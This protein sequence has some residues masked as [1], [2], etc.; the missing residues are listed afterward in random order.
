MLAVGKGN[1]ETVKFLLGVNA[2]F[3]V[4]DTKDRTCLFIAAE[5]NCVGVFKVCWSRV[6]P[7]YNGHD[8]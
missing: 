2:D 4:S 6:I 8:R 3:T 5:E 7:L 1:L